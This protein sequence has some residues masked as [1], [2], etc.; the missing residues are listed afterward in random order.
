MKHIVSF[1]GGKDSTA[2]LLMTLERGMPV[3][4]IVFCDT[5]KE[6]PAM[7]DHIAEVERYIGREITRIKAKKGFDYWL[8]D[9]IK[10]KGKNK[11]KRGYGWPDFRNR[12]CTGFLKRDEFKR[13]LRGKTVIEYHGIAI[14]ERERT[15]NNRGTGR[16]IRY[17]L[18][19]WSITEEQALQYCYDKGFDWGGLYKIFNRVSC[20]CCPLQSLRELENLYLYFPDLWERLKEMD[21]RA[22]N[23]FRADYSVEQLEQRFEKKLKNYS[24]SFFPIKRKEAE[25][26]DNKSHN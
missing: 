16:V 25:K 14:D 10:T 3:D 26:N 24:V 6:F 8:G 7:Y 11:G 2:M 20:W 21:K 13:Y 19:D 15:E 17:P 12:W 4:E 1:S 22:F 5:G 23:Q 18:V 9:H